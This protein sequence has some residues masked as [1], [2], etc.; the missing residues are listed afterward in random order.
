MHSLIYNPA[1]LW[2]RA[3]IRRGEMHNGRLSPVSLVG[4]PPIEPANFWPAAT[5]PAIVS[6]EE[7]AMSIGNQKI[8]SR[9]RQ[10]FAVSDYLPWVFTLV[11]TRKKRGLYPLL[12]V[13]RI[14]WP[15]GLKDYGNNTLGDKS[16]R[17]QEE[18]FA[19]A[20]PARHYYLIRPKRTAFDVC[21]EAMAAFEKEN[22]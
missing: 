11:S 1:C 21:A 19:V 10:Q 18:S 14:K 2:E 20:R 4:F 3:G 22:I 5:E 16:G 15:L 8:D 9:H 17:E 12:C 7:D 13:P 6:A